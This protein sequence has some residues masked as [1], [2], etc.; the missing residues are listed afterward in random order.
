MK[1]FDELIEFYKASGKEIDT[2]TITCHPSLLDVVIPESPM[3]Q[4][5]GQYKGYDLLLSNWIEKDK[6]IL[7]GSPFWIEHKVTTE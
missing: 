7:G 2:P 4:P 5:H 1:Q 6:V 3:I